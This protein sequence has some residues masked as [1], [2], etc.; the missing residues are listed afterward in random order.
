MEAGEELFWLVRRNSPQDELE[1]VPER[2]GEH[3]SMGREE[4]GGQA[5]SWDV[6]GK[7]APSLVPGTE[8]T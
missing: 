2:A 4:P 8:I 6:V 1:A 3:V 7:K 5:S